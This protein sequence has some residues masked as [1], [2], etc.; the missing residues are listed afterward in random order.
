MT[1]ILDLID[2]YP[3]KETV[4]IGFFMVNRQLQG[5]RVGSGIILELVQFLMQRGFKRVMLGIDKGNPQSTHFWKKNGFVVI[6][7]VPQDGGTILVAEKDL[8]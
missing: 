5:R 7:E 3:D 6:R 1:A 2:G 8:L 4:F